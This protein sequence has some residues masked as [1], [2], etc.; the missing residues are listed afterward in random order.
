MKILNTI[1][2]PVRIANIVANDIIGRNVI[3]V[4]GKGFIVQ[5]TNWD[6]PSDGY[7]IIYDY[8]TTIHYVIH[9]RHLT[10]EQILKLSNPINSLT[11]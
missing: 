11:P 3:E 4:A 10:D 2:D 6:I 1:S 7:K 8:S 5:F 9:L